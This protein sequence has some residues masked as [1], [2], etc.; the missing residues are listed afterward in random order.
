MTAD[1]FKQALRE[2]GLSRRQAAKALKVSTRTV[3]NW[4]KHGAPEWLPN[5]IKGLQSDKA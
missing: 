2:L 4:V 5:A 1:E 3:F